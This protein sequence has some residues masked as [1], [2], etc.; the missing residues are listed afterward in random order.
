VDH[1]RNPGLRRLDE[2]R[3][4]SL[5]ASLGSG[6]SGFEE[7]VVLQGAEIVLGERTIDLDHRLPEPAPEDRREPQVVDRGVLEEVRVRTFE[8]GL[9]G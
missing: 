9:R 8:L 5:D 4:I 2:V 7:K 6:G 1:Q 3:E